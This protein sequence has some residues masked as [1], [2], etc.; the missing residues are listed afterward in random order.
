MSRP[1]LTARWINLALLNYA[2]PPR[3]LGRHV[4]PGLELDTRDGDAFVSLVAFDFADTKVWGVPWPGYRHFPELNLRCYV[5][6]GDE[7]GVVFIREFVARRLV[8]WL[9]NRF[10]HEHFR[11]VPL[12]KRLIDAPTSLGVECRLTVGERTHRLAVTGSKPAVLPPESSL[13]HFF[14]EHRWG[15]GV[16]RRGETIRYEVVHPAW[17]IYP[18]QAC[19]VDLDW[20]E[21]YG[22]EWKFL[23]GRPPCSTVLS[24]GSAVAVYRGIKLASRECL[25][26]KHERPKECPMTK[27]D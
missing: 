2:V 14:K 25:M 5:R 10:Y 22:S 26:M 9:A 1:F 7:R 12:E 13:E 20:G 23:N 11:V 24:A 6:R 17:E 19:E 16:T 21:V 8:A 15:Y 27:P 3:V 18:V 4:P